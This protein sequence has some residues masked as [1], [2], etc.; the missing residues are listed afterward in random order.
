MEAEDQAMQQRLPSTEEEMRALQSGMKVL[1]VRHTRRMKQIVQR[2]GW[3]THSSVGEEA[4]AAAWLLVQHADHDRAFQRRVLALMEPLLAVGEVKVS[5]YAYLWDRTHD[6]QRYGTQGECVARGVWQPRTIEAPSEVDTR[7][8]AAGIFPP[9]L[10]DY[11]Q[12]MSALCEERH[13]LQSQ[14]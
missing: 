4:A 9:A 3:P 2:R 5:H 7:R 6:P 12:M 14:R 1:S 11:V 13:D 8:R 10:A